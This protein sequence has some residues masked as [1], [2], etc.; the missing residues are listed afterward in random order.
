M[1]ISLPMLEISL[2]GLPMVASVLPAVH[3]AWY[4][5]FEHQFVHTGTRDGGAV[6][7]QCTW[8]KPF[9]MRNVM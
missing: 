4:G 2:P 9:W 5:A 6:L 8:T 7:G 3:S 1:G